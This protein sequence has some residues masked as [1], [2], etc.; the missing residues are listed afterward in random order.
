MAKFPAKLD[1]LFEPARYKVL[2]GGRGGAKSWGIARALLILGG[3]KPLRIAC[4]REIQKSIADSVHQL[5]KDQ[6]TALELDHF[7]R[8]TDTY[9]EG[10]NGTI[11]TFHGLKH[12]VQNIKSLE[13]A[14]ICWVEEA[15]IVSKSSWNVLVPTIRKDGSEIWVSFNP[16]L[17]SDETY[18]RFVTKHPTGA[19][20]REINWRDNPWFPA[21]LRQEMEDLKRDDEDE[22]LHVWEGKCLITLAGAVYAKEIRSALLESRITKVP[23]DPSFPVHVIFDLGRSDLTAMWFVQIIGYEFRFV[24]YYENSGFAFGHY[25]KVLSEK[26]YHWGT[27]WLPHDADHDV[28]AAEKNV[29]QQAQAAHRDV[30]I[31]PH[32][33]TGAVAEGINMVRT[34]FPR[35]VFDEERCA[36][37]LHALKHY[38]YKVDESTGQRSKE[39]LHNWASHGSDA[40]R[41][42]AVSV[43]QPVKKLPRDPDRAT[44]THR[45]PG[46][47]MR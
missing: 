16:E 19:V 12:N 31:V 33:G 15:Q 23:Y 21:V 10:L 43:K 25:L 5:L 40:L 26:P 45:G 37:G 42:V 20:V 13:G 7:Y 32:L 9:I 14:D 6:I 36:D 4:C 30:Q 44:R 39:P 3:R 8:V 46:N 24:D 11:F 22:Y 17:E 2:R 1:F 18:R 28:I 47:W 41:Y 27:W 34:I 29:R 35:C 38:V